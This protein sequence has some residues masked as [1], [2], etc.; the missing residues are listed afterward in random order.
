MQSGLLPLWEK[1]PEGRMRG[2]AVS[3]ESH[4]LPME[5]FHILARAQEE[6]VRNE[7]QGRA[8]HFALLLFQEPGEASVDAFV[9]LGGIGD[10]YFAVGDE[11]RAAL[12]EPELAAGLC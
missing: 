11:H 9:F 12:L 5:L 7:Q 4:G 2:G 10:L 8:V 1:V 6:C 3:T